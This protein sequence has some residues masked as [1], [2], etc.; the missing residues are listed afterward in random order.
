[1]PFIGT[2]EFSSINPYGIEERKKI[3]ASLFDPSSRNIDN[4][5]FYQRNIY[6]LFDGALDIHYNDGTFQKVLPT[7]THEWN[8]YSDIWEY[9]KPCKIGTYRA[10]FFGVLLLGT[11]D[12]RNYRTSVRILE[13]GDAINQATEPGSFFAV[14]TKPS[15]FFEFNGSEVKNSRLYDLSQVGNEINLKAIDTCYLILL[16]P[17]S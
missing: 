13:K 17:K 11:I 6:C 9:H 4:N 15:N 10:T 3:A 16:S 5:N 12:S 1:M 14:M 7:Y 2:G 8:S